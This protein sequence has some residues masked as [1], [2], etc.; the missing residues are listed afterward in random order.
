VSSMSR[1]V[2]LFSDLVSREDSAISLPAAALA[3]AAVAYPELDLRASLAELEMMRAE[4]QVLV[5]ANPGRDKLE[6]LHELFFDRLGFAANRGDYYDPKNS[7]LNDVLQR[8]VGIPITLAVIFIDLGNAMGLSIEGVGFP[9][10]FLVRELEHGRILDVFGGGR[11]L[12]EADCK[13]LLAKQGIAGQ[14]RDEFL[15]GVARRQ[16]LSRMLN[17]LR[18]HYADGDEG[19]A[20]AAG[21]VEEMVAILDG[22]EDDAWRG[23]PIQ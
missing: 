18:R 13:R 6:L 9:G 8:R 7:F 20:G 21:A 10:H 11:E 16:M 12:V 17:N 14:W 23:L 22:L 3:V 1:A 4:A 15:D 19:S 2:R 5:R